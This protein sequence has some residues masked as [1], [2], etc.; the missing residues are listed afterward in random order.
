[1]YLGICANS[2]REYYRLFSTISASLVSPL[3][4][5]VHIK[6][7]RICCLKFVQNRKI[8]DYGI[9]GD[10]VKNSGC[11]RRGTLKYWIVQ[12]YI[13]FTAFPRQ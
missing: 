6:S 11:F 4:D 1:M 3:R 8:T 13:D 2:A 7:R 9:V 12:Q 10:I 5:A